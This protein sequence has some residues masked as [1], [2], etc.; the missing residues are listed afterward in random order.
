LTK[1]SFSSG[2]KSTYKSFSSGVKSTYKNK[3]GSAKL[4]KNNIYRLV[5]C[6]DYFTLCK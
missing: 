1:K 3:I 5:I 4:R 2:V 6:L